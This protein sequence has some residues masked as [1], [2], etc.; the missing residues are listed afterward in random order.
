KRRELFPV[1]RVSRRT[2]EALVCG[3]NDVHAA[4]IDA[5]MLDVFV[6]D[7]RHGHAAVEVVHDERAA[8]SAPACDAFPL[9]VRSKNADHGL[10]LEAVAQSPPEGVASHE[11]GALELHLERPLTSSPGQE[12]H[13][14]NAATSGKKRLRRRDR[15]R[16]PMAVAATELPAA[17][18]NGEGVLRPYIGIEEHTIRN[19]VRAGRLQKRQ[20]LD[21]IRHLCVALRRRPDLEVGAERSGDFIRKE[22]TERLAAD[23]P[24]DLADERT[25]GD[26]MVA[27]GRA[28]FPPWRLARQER[29]RL[30]A[31]EDIRDRDPLGPAWKPGA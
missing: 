4:V 7:V 6:H 29:H 11:V 8:G 16:V 13:A 1:S 25:E 5:A 20:A 21:Q 24:D 26:G 14:A 27:D 19:R 22:A 2:E 9:D 12:R 23:P 17:P 18:R 3:S 15:S 28:G 30:L 31:I 10:A